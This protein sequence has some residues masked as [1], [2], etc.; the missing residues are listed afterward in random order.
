LEDQSQIV[1]RASLSR[2]GTFHQQ[3]GQARRRSQL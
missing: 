3:Q 1:S 2:A